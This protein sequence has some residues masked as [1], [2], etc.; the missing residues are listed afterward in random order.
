MGVVG[1]GMVAG[2]ETVWGWGVGIPRL[3]SEWHGEQWGDWGWLTVR[4]VIGG[5]GVGDDRGVVGMAMGL[6][7]GALWGD[8]GGKR[9]GWRVCIWRGMGV[10][11]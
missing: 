7:E 11:W 3:R 9:D 4:G 8:D 5:N 1:L 6:G 2:V 10:R